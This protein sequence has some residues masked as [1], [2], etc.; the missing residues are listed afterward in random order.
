MPALRILISV[1]PSD[2]EEVRDLPDEKNHEK[3]KALWVESTLNANPTDEW[4]HSSG[5]STDKGIPSGELFKWGVNEHI[6]NQ[7]GECENCGKDVWDG[8]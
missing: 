6:R 7:G 8:D 4:W 3:C 2:G 1:K 5:N